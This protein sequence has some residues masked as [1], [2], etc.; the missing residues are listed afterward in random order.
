VNSEALARLREEELPP[1]TKG[2]PLDG[3][4]HSVDSVG[5][6]G[7]SVLAGDLPFPLLA[8]SRS[9][10]EHNLATM[11]VYCREQEVLLAPHGKTTMAPQLF[12][13]QLD[14]GSWAITAATPNE[15]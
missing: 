2:L 14:A 4:A 5:A 10:L 3:R 11:A 1:G 12:D 7:W 15:R 8:L 9:A 13:R 6:A